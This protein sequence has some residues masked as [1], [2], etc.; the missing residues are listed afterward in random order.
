M[1]F[2]VMAKNFSNVIVSECEVAV[3]LI[4]L[5]LGAVSLFCLGMSF[6]RVINMRVLRCNKNLVPACEPV[7]WEL[8]QA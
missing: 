5:F 7:H 1:I 6:K 3:V 2:A 8:L 4:A